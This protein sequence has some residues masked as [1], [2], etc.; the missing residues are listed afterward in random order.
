MGE[1]AD[2][3]VDVLLLRSGLGG[4]GRD[5]LRA[6]DLQAGDPRLS[7]SGL[8][9]VP[10]PCRAFDPTLP[11]ETDRANAQCYGNNGRDQGPGPHAA[12]PSA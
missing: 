9:L 8:N 2:R 11:V 7:L 3:L 6:F 1:I 10:G 12:S 5:G 4:A